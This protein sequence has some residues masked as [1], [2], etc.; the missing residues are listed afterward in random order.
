MVVKDIVQ[1]IVGLVRFMKL[2]E[3]NNRRRRSEKLRT[4]TRNQTT[5]TTLST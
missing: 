3:M 1:L 4:L 2:L 5:K